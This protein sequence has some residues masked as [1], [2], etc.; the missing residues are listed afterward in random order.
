MEDADAVVDTTAAD[1]VLLDRAAE[2]DDSILGRLLGTTDVGE[3]L[4]LTISC[5]HSV[6]TL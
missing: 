6:S 1:A 3:S 2:E 5:V 4:K